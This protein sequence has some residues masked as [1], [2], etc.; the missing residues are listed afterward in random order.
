MSVN[1]LRMS[2]I[3][4]SDEK[5]VLRQEVING[6]LRRYA[7][8]PSSKNSRS[9]Y[10]DINHYAG[11]DPKGKELI[12]YRFKKKTKP[13]KRT[14]E[15]A[16]NLVTDK[17]EWGASPEVRDL[18]CYYAFEL[19]WEEKMQ[20]LEG[21]TFDLKVE[22]VRSDEIRGTGND[23][24]TP[25][26][27]EEPK[28][29]TEISNP[30]GFRSWFVKNKFALIIPTAILIVVIAIL[31][32]KAKE[33]PL[34]D[35]FEKKQ[36]ETVLALYKKLKGYSLDIKFVLRSRYRFTA[37]W[38]KDS[39]DYFYEGRIRSIPFLR[40]SE[41]LF[42]SKKAISEKYFDAKIGVMELSSPNQI[43]DYFGNGIYKFDNSVL[44]YD[45]ALLAKVRLRD[46][47]FSSEEII[48]SEIIEYAKSPLLPDSIKS[49]LFLLGLH[50]ADPQSLNTILDN[51]TTELVIIGNKG[52][53]NKNLSGTTLL[54]TWKDLHDS[55]QQFTLLDIINMIRELEKSIIDFLNE[56][57]IPVQ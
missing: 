39:T 5:I 10:E 1:I 56:K 26:P 12:I 35:D 25:P 48:D 18:L 4:R 50:F 28:T 55:S 37:F 46:I 44:P 57:E 19:S 33:N 32:I 41:E 52:T 40:I 45:S 51:S 9:V 6:I 27:T 21:A 2:R 36:V 11:V 31:I 47:S 16:F 34:K 49:R 20:K 42:P 43:L 22:R 17:K 13:D 29:D 30:N 8:R 14:I 23:T 54:Y 24:K 15:R 7:D 3:G 53:I 38:V